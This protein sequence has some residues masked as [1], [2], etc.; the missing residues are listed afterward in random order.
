MWN[1]GSAPVSGFHL[2][3]DT[4]ILCQRLNRTEEVSLGFQTSYMGENIPIGTY[5][6]M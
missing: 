6:V 2:L 1:I 5:L 3:D 4:G